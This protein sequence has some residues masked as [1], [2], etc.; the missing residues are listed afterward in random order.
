[1]KHFVF[2]LLFWGISHF[3]FAT[4]FYVSTTGNDANPGTKRAPFS[5]I[6]KAQHVVLEKMKTNPNENCTIWLQGGEYQIENN[7]VFDSND[8]NGTGSITFKAMRNQ[9]PVIS[10][11]IKITGW[12]K[13]SSGLWVAKLSENQFN[14]IPRELFVGGKRAIR[15]RHPNNEYLQVKKAGADRRTN[16]FFEEGDFPIPHDVENTELVL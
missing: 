15:A 8:F 11:G 16:F 5:T 9:K 4:D 7:I 6:E 10:G 13:N 2:F 1:M 12:Q 3:A 14:G